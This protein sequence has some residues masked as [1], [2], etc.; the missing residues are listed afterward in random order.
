MALKTKYA[1]KDEIPKGSEEHYKEVDGAWVLDADFEDVGPLKRAKE[2]EAKARKTA[3]DALKAA[4]D[5]LTAKQTELD[6]MREGAIPKADVAALKNSYEAKLA[7]VTGEKDAEIGSLRGSLDKHVLQGTVDK[8]AVEL[9]DKNATIGKPHIAGRLKIE[10]ENGEHVVKVLDRDGKPSASTVDD[11]KKEILQ[12]KTFAGILVGSRSSG[13]GA[14]G[15]QGGS[16]AP[17]GDNKSFDAAKA[18]TKDLVAHI[19]S[20]RE[21]S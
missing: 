21:A 19:D 11:L 15:G 18:T 5:E 17:S 9:F 6:G 3:E 10:Q 2:H 7:K 13:G 14:N 12:D 8:L 20:K 16:G 4:Q 1:K